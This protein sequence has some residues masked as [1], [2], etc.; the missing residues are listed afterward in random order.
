MDS[1]PLVSVI[2]NCYNSAKYLA[3]A[4]DSVYSQT[5]Q[6]WEIVFWDNASTDNSPEIAKSFDHRL[7]YFRGEVTVPL[8]EARNFAIEQCKGQFIAFL[9]CDDLWF[10]GKLA[11]QIPLFE[12]QSVGLVY[13]DSLFFRE[14]GKEKKNFS[15]KCPLSG[16]VF[17]ELLND[18]I[19]DIE[20]VVIRRSV[21]DAYGL[22]F[23]RSLNL[24]GDFD[25][26]C[27]V[28]YYSSID[29][30]SDVLVR[31]RIHDDNLSFKMKDQ[32]AVELEN[33]YHKFLKLYPDVLNFS[34]TKGLLSRIQFMKA[35]DYW[36]SGCAVSARRMLSKAENSKR[37]FLLYIVTFFPYKFVSWIARRSALL[38]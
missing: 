28:A 8:Y 38:L 17:N 11:K 36:E 24:V 33:V 16:R 31:Y 19:L 5:Y 34:N 14:N 9:D 10:E 25:L 27:Q 18:Y 4:I 23:D 37:K 32:F 29:Y 22:K 26:F 1:E 13:C 7:R 20:S 21:L 30:V 35:R 6:N 12:D 15:N 3:A 2:M